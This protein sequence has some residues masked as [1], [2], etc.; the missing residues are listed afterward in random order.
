MSTGSV[1]WGWVGGNGSPADTEGG[2]MHACFPWAAILRTRTWEKV[3]PNSG[4]QFWERMGCSASLV[5]SDVKPRRCQSLPRARACFPHVRLQ[6]GCL[7]PPAPGWEV[8]DLCLK[9]SLLLT[10]A[11]DSLEGMRFHT[12]EDIR[13]LVRGKLVCLVRRILG[14]LSPCDAAVLCA[15]CLCPF[16]QL[17][18][19]GSGPPQMQGCLGRAGR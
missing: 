4:V 12:K 18:P 14:E 9:Q 8:N 17:S 3:L 5:L 1:T 16:H 11:D 6:C 13:T 7:T 2:P 15:R 10:P 19:S